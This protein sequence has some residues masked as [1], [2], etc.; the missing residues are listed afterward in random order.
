M[1]K[2]SDEYTISYDKTGM[3]TGD[4][5]VINNGQS[6]HVICNQPD[7]SGFTA[8]QGNGDWYGQNTLTNGALCQSYYASGTV[9]YYYSL[10]VD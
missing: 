1:A 6:H 5:V 4:V 9:M 3:Q 2:S 10:N 7:D 8:L